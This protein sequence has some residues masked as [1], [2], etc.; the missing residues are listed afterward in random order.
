[1]SKKIKP[2][3]LRL[4]RAVIMR[5]GSTDRQLRLDLG[6]QPGE[7]TADFAAAERGGFVHHFDV[8]GGE[9][10]SYPT[11]RALDA[12]LGARKPPRSAATIQAAPVKAARRRTGTR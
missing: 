5:P 4:V 7:L 3:T 10:V 9:I 8:G 2:S 11:V 6:A 12:V 1:M